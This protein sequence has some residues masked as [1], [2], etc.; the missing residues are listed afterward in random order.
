MVLESVHGN[1]YNTQSTRKPKHKHKRDGSGPTVCNNHKY[2]LSDLDEF[3]HIESKPSKLEEDNVTRK[4]E[5]TV[6]SP[7]DFSIKD[8]K[9]EEVEKVE[10]VK[11][12]VQN[13]TDDED[14]EMI[15]DTVDNSLQPDF[16]EYPNTNYPNIDFKMKTDKLPTVT[17]LFV[18][19]T[20][21]IISHLD[22]LEELRLL[23]STYH[24]TIM[25][26]RYTIRELDGLKNGNTAKEKKNFELKKGRD[27][28]EAAR[29]GNTW[30]YNHLANMDSGVIGQKLTQR[31]DINVVKDDAILDC[32]VYFKERKNCFVILLSN[33]KNL[34]LKALTDDILTVSYRDGMTGDLIAK[35]A[36]EENTFRYG[37]MNEPHEDVSVAPT[38]EYQNSNDEIHKKYTFKETSDIIFHEIVIAVLE[39]IA[40]ILRDEYG[41]SIDFLDFD[42]TMLENLADASR[43]V[44]KYWV[45]VFSEYFRGGKLQ[46]DS[47][48]LLPAQLTT[49]PQDM[50]TLTIFQQFWS[51]IL[52]H[53]FIKRSPEE[54]D[55]LQLCIQQWENR[56]KNVI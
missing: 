8:E 28:G 53:F 18:V 51:D 42:P 19:D 32:C 44:Y 3:L 7:K 25:I 27:V 37:S 4:F 17:T 21:F 29:M 45:S 11:E 14:V 50:S 33:D 15:L 20:N 30:I 55:K 43:C 38:A 40:Y 36:F 39:S 34:C 47:W 10:E 56:M 49:I 54:Q 5:P 24:H 13:V 23:Y 46:K 12:P 26:P 52:E 6:E 41:D 31:M 1:N 16:T 2:S 22:I 35:T 48:K 9:I